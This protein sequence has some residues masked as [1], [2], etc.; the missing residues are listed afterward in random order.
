MPSSL[1]VTFESGRPEVVLETHV[2]GL[3]LRGHRCK[4]NQAAASLG[5]RSLREFFAPP[6]GK[7]RWFGVADGLHA[8]RG[9]L[10]ALRARPPVVYSVEASLAD[11][12]RLE[13]V[14]SVVPE[15]RFRLAI[16]T[17]KAS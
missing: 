5:L 13:R 6:G 10:A 14:L 1:R 9:L 8:V 7:S 11:L 3:A 4:V 15:G 12:S 17:E 16:V 2:C